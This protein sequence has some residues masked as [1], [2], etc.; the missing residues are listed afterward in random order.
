MAICIGI[1]WKARTEDNAPLPTPYIRAVE[2]GGG[3]EVVLLTP[4]PGVHPERVLDEIHGL[5]LP[6]GVDVHPRHYGQDPHPLLGQVDEERDALELFLIQEAL[7][8]D[9]PILAICRGIQVLNVAAGGTLF[10]DLSI[11]GVDAARHRTTEPE[12]GIAHQLSIRE[13]SL[14]Q[15]IVGVREM[16]VNTFH[17]QAVD[18]VARG[19]VVTAQSEDG[20]VEA[21]ESTKHRFV[22]GVQWH[23][24][25]M[26]DHHP[27]QRKL[28][29]AFLSAARAS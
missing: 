29:E 13:G 28:F 5:L 15:A 21:I 18:R 10:Q 14:L 4:A 24:E 16:G 25:R 23:P 22:L 3:V 19:F 7:R 2:Q 12:W 26:V 9:L 1:T 17:H 6:G 8:R 11:A 20:V 27:L